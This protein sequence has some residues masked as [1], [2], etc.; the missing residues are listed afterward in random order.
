[1]ILPDLCPCCGKDDLCVVSDYGGG[2]GR[3]EC[4]ECGAAVYRKDGE[5]SFAAS[6]TI[7]A[8]RVASADSFRLWEDGYETD[9]DS[10]YGDR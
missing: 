2:D 5:V 10:S 9:C 8:A 3:A 6:R 4:I 1:M 7:R